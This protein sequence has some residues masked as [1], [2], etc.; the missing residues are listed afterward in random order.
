MPRK[1]LPGARFMQSL[2]QANMARRQ[3]KG[4]KRAEGQRD[5]GTAGTEEHMWQCLKLGL[6]K[7]NAKCR[8]GADAR[9]IK[10]HAAQCS[11]HFKCVCVGHWILEWH[12][13]THLTK[14]SLDSIHLPLAAICTHAIRLWCS[15]RQG[16]RQKREREGR[17]VLGPMGWLC[18]LSSLASVLAHYE[19]RWI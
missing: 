8:C 7:V 9:Q 13:H 6:I 1:G 11:T 2:Q 5:S 16:W 3:S 10:W 18:G 17:G 19:C 4:I 15:T 14:H 12:S